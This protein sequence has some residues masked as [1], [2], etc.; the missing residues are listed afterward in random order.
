MHAKKPN[1]LRFLLL[2]ESVSTSGDRGLMK[3]LGDLQHYYALVSPF[4]WYSPKICDCL[5]STFSSQ[6]NNNEYKSA[7][8][9]IER[10]FGDWINVVKGRVDILPVVTEF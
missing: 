5:I 8:E 10:N 3:L 1:I 6:L 7:M 9:H 4:P 2:L